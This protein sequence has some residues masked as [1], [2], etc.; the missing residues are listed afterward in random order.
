MP[1]PNVYAGSVPISAG[2]HKLDK[3]GRDIGELV[4][5][6]TCPCGCNQKPKK[7]RF[8]CRRPGPTDLI[9]EEQN[10]SSYLYRPI[11]HK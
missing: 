7:I 8:H 5:S 6:E 1:I 2:N 3:Y 9:W 4:H 10:P 11:T